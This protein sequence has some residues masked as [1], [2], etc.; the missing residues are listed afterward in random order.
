MRRRPVVIVLV[1]ASALIPAV[2]LRS[3]RFESQWFERRCISGYL[4]DRAD[5]LLLIL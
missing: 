4:R 5:G 3:V 2:A 1:K